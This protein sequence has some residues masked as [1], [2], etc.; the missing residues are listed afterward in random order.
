MNMI[1]KITCLPSYFQGRHDKLI[2]SM[3]FLLKSD[4]GKGQERGSSDCHKK[5][6]SLTIMGNIKMCV[7][8]TSQVYCKLCT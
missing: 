3:N 7:A 8:M 4:G 5:Y 6:R 1:E 2:E